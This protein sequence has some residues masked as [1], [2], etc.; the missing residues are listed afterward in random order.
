LE[1]YEIKRECQWLKNTLGFF[2]PFFGFAIELEEL[3]TGVEALREADVL[4]F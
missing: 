2:L 4:V 3:A 1:T